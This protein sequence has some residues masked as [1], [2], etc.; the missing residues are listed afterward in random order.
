VTFTEFAPAQWQAIQAVRADWPAEIDWSAV[1]SELEQAGRDFWAMRARRRRR[2]PKAMRARLQRA[3]K[4]L[5]ELDQLVID[6]GIDHTFIGL[7]RELENR[8]A[9][10]E[11]WGGRSFGGTRDAHRELLYLRVIQQW[12]GAL[13]GELKFSRADEAA[14][15]PAVRYFSAVLTPRTAKSR[16]N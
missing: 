12:T 4:R 11:A 15:G 5:G 2:P 7:R 13:Q 6:L 16:S 10:Y 1:R 3:L 9:L 14:S 8:L